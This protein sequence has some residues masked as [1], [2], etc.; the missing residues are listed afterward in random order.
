[1]SFVIEITRKYNPN[2]AKKVLNNIVKYFGL[3]EWYTSYAL[4][5]MI[6]GTGFLADCNNAIYGFST[7]FSIGTT[8]TTEQFEYRKEIKYNKNL[9]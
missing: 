1:M 4:D 9:K 2:E 6:I 7:T 3:G 8:N 5:K